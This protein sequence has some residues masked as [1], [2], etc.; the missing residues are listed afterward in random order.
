MWEKIEAI[1]LLIFFVIWSLGWL[2]T[3]IALKA[4]LFYMKA[5]K[6]APPNKALFYMKAKK[7]APPNKAEL[8][9]WCRYAAKHSFGL[10]ENL[11]D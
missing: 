2:I 1:M 8:K 7:Y 11:P 9:K 6:Y 3:Y 4:V 10:V 5:K